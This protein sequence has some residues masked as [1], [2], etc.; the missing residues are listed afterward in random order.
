M[1]ISFIEKFIRNLLPY[2]TIYRQIISVKKV[3]WPKSCRGSLHEAHSH[4]ALKPHISY[5]VVDVS[6]SVNLFA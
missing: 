2:L 3:D 5:V 1:A 4:A 6:N